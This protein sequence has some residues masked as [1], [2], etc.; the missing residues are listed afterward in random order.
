MV[1][2]V[3]EKSQPDGTFYRLGIGCVLPQKLLSVVAGLVRLF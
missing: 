1:V 3:F 2:F